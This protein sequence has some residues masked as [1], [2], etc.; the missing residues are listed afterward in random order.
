MGGW[1]LFLSQLGLL[2]AMIDEYRQRMPQSRFA[3]LPSR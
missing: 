1:P 3:L 2:F